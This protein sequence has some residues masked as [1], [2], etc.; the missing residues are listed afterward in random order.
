MLNGM[1]KEQLLNFI[2]Q[3]GNER[4]QAL[5]DVAKFQTSD[6]HHTK[7]VQGYVNVEVDRLRSE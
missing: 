5:F 1:S 7:A 2:A 3:K 6:C 4:K